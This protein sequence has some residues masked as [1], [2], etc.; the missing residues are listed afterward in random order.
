MTAT[1]GLSTRATALTAV[2]WAT[3]IL[4][5]VVSGLSLAALLAPTPPDLVALHGLTIALIALTVSSW[6]LVAFSLAMVFSAAA[7]LLSLW[8]LSASHGAPLLWTDVIALVV[9]NGLAGTRQHRLQRRMHRLKQQVNDVSE[10]VSLQAQELRQAQQSHEAL[11]YKLARYQRLHAIAEELVRLVELETI[12]QLA[13]EQAFAL[14]GKSEACL[15]LL[16][17]KPRPTRGY[18]RA[19]ALRASKRGEGLSPI[20]MKLGDQFDHYVVRT[21]RPLLVN[22]V[23]RDF[24]FTAS[25]ATDRP[26]G[27]VLG[28]SHTLRA[29]VAGVLRL[30]SG[31][32]QAYTQDDLRFLD[33]LLDLLN[34]AL[35]NARLFAQTQQLAITDGLTDLYRRQPFL[36]QLAR[37]VARA[38]RSRESL[39]VMMLDIDHF[40]RYNDTY[41]H[42]AG[43]LILKAVASLMRKTIPPD[44]ICARYGG[45]E[46]AIV[47]PK[48]SKAVG[49]EIA[50]RLRQSV[51]AHVRPMGN[52]QR[53]AV[54][55]S[56]VVA[57]FP[58]DAQSDLELIRRSDQRLYHAKRSGRNQVCST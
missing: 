16:A 2:K 34:T 7:G 36:E 39:A 40:K 8:M 54:T 57:T 13:V 58:E 56:V 19:L 4:W 3:A 51:E 32:P 49:T 46:F 26:I 11:T 9:L 31:R 43:D 15:L 35:A 50:D 1:R 52:G 23:R 10:G 21:Q 28:R 22:D 44:G 27:S 6:L 29:E 53:D 45:E 25:A 24:R 48:A 18:H 42:S 37:E 38:S 47:L 30:H 20:Q 17:D 55:V 14:I 5:V 33:I 12:A 41:G